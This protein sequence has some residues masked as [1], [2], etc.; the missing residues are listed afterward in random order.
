VPTIDVAAAEQYGEL[1]QI[2]PIDTDVDR[3]VQA[4]VDDVIQELGSGYD[5]EDDYVLAVG[6]L[7]CCAAA[8]AVVLADQGECNVLRW[9]KHTK[10]YS[11]VKVTA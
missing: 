5:V 2:I 11:V 4:C 1:R 7:V 9:S 8:V 3:N 10:S 6:D